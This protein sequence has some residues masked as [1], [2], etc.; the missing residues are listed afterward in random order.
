[1]PDLLVV[2]ASTQTEEC[3]IPLAAAL[4][5][6]NVSWRC[7]VTGDG[8]HVL[9]NPAIVA[10]LAPAEPIACQHSWTIEFGENTPCPITGGSQYNLSSMIGQN[11]RVLSL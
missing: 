5:R 7:F 8:I 1:M 11:A 2:I 10:A 3:I 4:A 6:A 9:T